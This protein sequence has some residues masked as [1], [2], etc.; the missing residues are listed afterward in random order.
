[1]VAKCGLQKHVANEFQGIQNPN[2]FNF[3]FASPLG[4]TQAPTLQQGPQGFQPSHTLRFNPFA[5]QTSAFDPLF[6]FATSTP[7]FPLYLPGS[8]ATMREQDGIVGFRSPFQQ[9]NTFPYPGVE[10][11]HAH[12]AT[13]TPPT[14]ASTG[15]SVEAASAARVTESGTTEMAA[16]LAL[17]SKSPPTFT[18]SPASANTNLSS[19]SSQGSAQTSAL[20]PLQPQASTQPAA[21]ATWL[22][23]RSHIPDPN[24]FAP[25][26]QPPFDRTQPPPAAPTLRPGNQAMRQRAANN[27]NGKNYGQNLIGCPPVNV[28][29][30]L[31]V[32]ISIREILT[33][34]PEWLHI[35]D[36]AM[37]TECN[38]FKRGDLAKMQLH[39]LNQLTKEEMKACGDRIQKQRSSG[40]R[41]YNGKSPTGGRKELT[42]K[43]K[44]VRG[45]H[46]N[47]LTANDWELKS[48]YGPDSRPMD[49]GHIKL[50]DIYGRVPIANWPQG[51]DRLIFTECLEYAAQ[52]PQFDLDTSHF[53]WIIQTQGLQ[54]SA[55]G[56]GGDFDVAALNRFSQAVPTPRV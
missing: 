45:H 28:Q 50:R 34:C 51:P 41:I 18:S 55:T 9:Q 35:P 25:Q 22:S 14:V 19:A 10:G 15:S 23:K 38:E 11:M 31:N 16:P 13:S 29:P 46:H 33:F 17:L 1:M 54:D 3:T 7:R 21:Q 27:R 32:T 48:Q 43:S 53:D 6:N 40:C 37:R 5:Q 4:S 44:T 8:Q 42:W 47:D 56:A 26:A 12:F 49:F 39:P 52:N 2:Y 36:V 30:P 24:R 20:A